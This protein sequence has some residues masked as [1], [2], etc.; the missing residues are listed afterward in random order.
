MFYIFKFENAQFR[1]KH[2]YWQRRTRSNHLQHYLSAVYC[3]DHRAAGRC[4]IFQFLLYPTL[5]WD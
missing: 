4:L 5:D 2:L 3:F 1:T